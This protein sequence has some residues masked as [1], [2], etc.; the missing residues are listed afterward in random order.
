[1]SLRENLKPALRA[2]TANWRPM[3]LIQIGAIAIVGSY[4]QFP[5]MRAWCAELAAFK[6][7]EGLQFSAMVGAMAGGVLPEISK[8]ITG[9]R[10]KLHSWRQFLL[11]CFVFVCMAVSVDIMYAYFGRLY[12]M[13]HNPITVLKK[14]ASDMG[15]FCPIVAVPGSVLAFTWMDYG[16]S[17]PAAKQSF[18][19]GGFWQRYIQMLL[20]NWMMWIPIL[21]AVYALPVNLQFLMAQLA[22]AA[23]SILV[24][25]I[26]TAER[27]A[28][29]PGPV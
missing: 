14:T 3:L 20:P 26:S 13:D 22:E 9:D 7:R 29:A 18:R 8:L 27:P 23:W 19:G 10:E 4:Y 1:M 15:V 2:V 21:F 28:P 16:F 12:G 11:V 25:Y 5:S 17:W 6:A 24:V